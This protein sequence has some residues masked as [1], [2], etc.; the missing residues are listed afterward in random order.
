MA[1]LPPPPDKHAAAIEFVATKTIEKLE[2][3]K[4]TEDTRFEQLFSTAK[5]SSFNDDSEVSSFVD[6][7]KG[8]CDAR[9][10]EMWIEFAH[11]D[12]LMMKHSSKH[13]KGDKT[14]A[15][16][17]DSEI[18]VEHDIF[19]EMSKW[20]KS[21]PK[22]E[23]YEIWIMYNNDRDNLSDENH[24][25]LFAITAGHLCTLLIADY[26][27]THKIFQAEEKSFE[28]RR[29]KLAHDDK[30]AGD[31]EK[32]WQLY[33]SALGASFKSDKCADEVVT[34]VQIEVAEKPNIAGSFLHALED[35]YVQKFNQL[36]DAAL[37]SSNLVDFVLHEYNV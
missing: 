5:K 20:I 12:H 26:H 29:R 14:R 9:G 17:R 30:V 35:V 13:E 37:M 7:L 10:N 2:N 34:A 27:R 6:H 32:S 4:K 15:H 11:V 16:H 36:T 24:R 3:I 23:V 1:P 31:V 25:K 18:K 33:T 21:D 22:S 19:T 8:L 28:G